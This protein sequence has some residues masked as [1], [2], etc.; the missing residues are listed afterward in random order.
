MS[1][2]SNIHT[3]VPFVAGTTKAF[4][5]QRLIKVGYK[6][7]KDKKTGAEIPPK[8]P[9]IAI[10]VPFLDDSSI[11]E[12]TEDF[13]PYIK[14]M[15]ET[16]QDGIVTSLYES[17]DGVLSQVSDDELN[18]DSVLS[19]LEAESLGGRLTKDAIAAW[20]DSQV[21]DN[22]FVIVAEKLKFTEPNAEQTKT[23]E[24]HV[25]TYRDVMAMLA[26]G[27]TILTPSQIKGC[28]HAISLAG[29]A[30]EI[31]QKLTARIASMEKPKAVAE[32]LEL[33]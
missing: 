30:G 20:F 10:S 25:K 11:A 32:L 4:T 1:N 24:K 22:L 33:E 9:S 16:A 28:K 3:V 21:A 19:F 17:R 12:R 27:K 2:V 18:L 6:T 5:D 29:D 31:G 26:G 14:A 8:Y 15:I 13:L 7:T 23:I